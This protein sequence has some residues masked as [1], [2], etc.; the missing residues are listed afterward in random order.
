VK[1]I[2]LH[3]PPA[4]GKYTIARRL[5]AAWGALN[6]HNHVTL[7]VA[8]SL[9]EFGTPEFWNLAHRL[10]LIALEAK[11]SDPNATVVFTSCYSQPDDDADVAALEEVVAEHGGEFIPVYLQCGIDELRRRVDGGSRAAMRKVT[12]IQGLDGFL[13]RYNCVALARP[14]CITVATEGRTAAVCAGEIAQRLGLEQWNN[15]G[16]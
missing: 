3:G 16:V 11:A 8:S 9:F 14:T 15:R 4:S 1:L 2:F 5:H 6:F 7:D 10:R 12:T 13:A